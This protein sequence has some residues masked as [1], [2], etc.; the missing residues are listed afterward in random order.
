[1][2]REEKYRV[3]C[4]LSGWNEQTDSPLLARII[5]RESCELHMC[6]LSVDLWKVGET[7]GKFLSSR[8]NRFRHSMT[9]VLFLE[10]E[11]FSQESV[12]SQQR[13]IAYGFDES[14]IG[15]ENKNF[16]ILFLVN[17]DTRIRSNFR[18]V[19][20]FIIF[21]ETLFSHQSLCLSRARRGASDKEKSILNHC[22]RNYNVVQISN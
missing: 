18:L 6:T 19:V 17:R 5:A 21:L 15:E 12:L 4:S 10:N 3:K 8:M 13:I 2:K 7:G 11:C 14:E 9:L 22:I 20:Q 1:M 16:V